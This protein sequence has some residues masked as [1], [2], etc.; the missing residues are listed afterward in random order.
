MKA[1]SFSVEIFR[2]YTNNPKFIIS[3]LVSV[4]LLFSGLLCYDHHASTIKNENEILGYITYKTR[5]IKTKAD[6]TVVWYD[7]EDKQ[8][9]TRRD[10]I[11]A[12]ELSNAVVT[13]N[14]GTELRID[15]NSMVILDFSDKNIK[16]DFKYGSIQTK[17]K[18]KG[19]TKLEI[20]AGDAK[21]YLTDGDLSLSREENGQLKIISNRGQVNVIN[22][23]NKVIL[24]ENTR[25]E[26][27]KE[28]SSLVKEQG[29]IL[30]TPEPM[31]FISTKEPSEFISFSW[32][33][34]EGDNKLEIGKEIGFK[35]IYYSKD[36]KANLDN[37]KL[38]IG[39]YYWRVKSKNEVSEPR[40]FTLI[41]ESPFL[42]R[43]PRANEEF[44]FSGN[45]LFINFA[46]NHL[47]DI[48]K[49]SV[50]LA[51]DNN[52]NSILKKQEAKSNSISL[53]L[54]NEGIY[55][56]R[57]GAEFNNPDFAQKYSNIRTFTIKKISQ[58]PPP[59]LISPL[60]NSVLDNKKRILLNWTADNYD[61]FLVKV[62]TDA[63]FTS[64]ILEKNLTDN[65]IL[66]PIIDENKT[67]YWSV[68]GV[69]S[70]L[71]QKNTSTTNQ[72]SIQ[73]KEIIAASNLK[74][75]T[76]FDVPVTELSNDMKQSVS[77]KEK[78]FTAPILIEPIQDLILEESKIP[79]LK[80]SWKKQDLKLKYTLFIYKLIS[81]KEELFHNVTTTKNFLELK[82][83]KLLTKGDYVWILESKF[84]D[85]ENKI[86]SKKS[87]KRSYTILPALTP[88]TIKKNSD[89][90]YLEE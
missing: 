17:R 75:E 3:F 51:T 58:L 2:E 50:E 16:L 25:L 61:S 78:T 80:F 53:E 85:K 39:S 41:E 73:E 44:I 38:P 71:S 72:F 64:N 1:L 35:N 87:V 69:A 28:G 46:W 37:V 86:Q 23:K 26:I 74:E 67:Y 84:K 15:E 45:P 36:L 83:E 47:V 63:N 65:Y 89:I 48:K 82:D 9:I 55:Y 49:Y 43:S 18:E 57:I 7:V 14:D 20:V 68:E 27:Q 81:E 22:G 5:V 52:F 31:K 34:K 8:P 88:P 79:N 77:E 33:N 12:E 6:S 56:Y 32:K 21:V 30:L 62:S 4:A 40:K 70:K 13:L 24:K 76:N 29:I 19:D 60:N 11:R 10:T 90:Y 59:K 66:L 42:I 54:L